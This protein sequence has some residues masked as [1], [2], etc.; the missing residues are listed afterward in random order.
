MKYLKYLNGSRNTTTRTRKKKERN[1][2]NEIHL[3]Y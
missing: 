1:K 3:K 2:V